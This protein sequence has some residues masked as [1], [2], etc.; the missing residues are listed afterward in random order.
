M[1]IEV[2]GFGSALAA[3][4]A[5]LDDEVV[6]IVGAVGIIGPVESDTPGRRFTFA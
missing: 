1:F 4:H 5:A 2:A 6:F 3:F